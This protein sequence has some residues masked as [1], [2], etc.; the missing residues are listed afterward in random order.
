MLGLVRWHRRRPHRQACR[1]LDL[2]GVGLL[3]GGD[4]L[5]QPAHPVDGLEGYFHTHTLTPFAI[6]GTLA[7]LF[8]LG[9]LTLT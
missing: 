5:V 4:L 9:W 2:A 6:Y 3:A 7:G 8:S 1:E